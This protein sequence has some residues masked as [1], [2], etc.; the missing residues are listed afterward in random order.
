M[1]AGQRRQRSGRKVCPGKINR[2]CRGDWTVLNVILVLVPAS[3]CLIWG[4]SESLV[5]VRM[6]G[7]RSHPWEVLNQ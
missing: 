5:L 3:D 7:P 2:G 1:R 6:Q 4:I